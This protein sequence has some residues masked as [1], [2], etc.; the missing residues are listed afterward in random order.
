LDY[1]AISGDQDSYK[2][3]HKPYQ[4]NREMEELHTVEA[5]EAKFI[6]NCWDNMDKK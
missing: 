2:C 1:G 3:Y 4:E 5:L 6:K